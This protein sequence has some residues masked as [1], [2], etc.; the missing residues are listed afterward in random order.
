MACPITQ[1]GHKKLSLGQIT[2]F[3]G[4]GQLADVTRRL[5]TMFGDRARCPLVVHAVH[6]TLYLQI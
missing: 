5:H 2:F 4:D 6:E 1:G 3:L